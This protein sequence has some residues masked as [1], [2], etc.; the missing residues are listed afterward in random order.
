MLILEI[1]PCYAQD[2][3][4][5]SMKFTEQEKA[6]DYQSQ[7]AGAPNAKLASVS[8]LRHFVMVDQPAKFQQAVHDVIATL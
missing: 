8:P 7:L 1:L 3:S 5:P 6:G 4:K 2:V